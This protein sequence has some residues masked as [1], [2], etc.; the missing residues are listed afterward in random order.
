M[1]KIR[2]Q[3][4]YSLIEL[5]LVLV[6]IG[7]IASIAFRSLG[8]VTETA[9]V[10]ETRSEMERLADAITGD[11]NSVSGGHRIDYGYLGDVGAL[12]PNLDALVANPGGYATWNGPY[13]RD[14][15]SSGGADTYY[16]VD[17]WG[18]PYA[19]S[20]GLTITSNGGGSSLTRRLAN[21]NA[22]LLSNNVRGVILDIDGTPPGPL[23]RDS[24]IVRLYHP[25]G[26][27]GLRTRV[28][29]PG[30]DGFY[31]L[32]SVPVGS[33][34]LQVIYEPTDDTLTRRIDINPGA[35]FYSEIHFYGNIWSGGLSAN[36]LILRPIAE[37]SATNL[38]AEP[39]GPGSLNWDRVNDQFADEDNSY[40]WHSS[41]SYVR[42]LYV[43][44]DPTASGT[45]DSVI[46]V[47]RCK[48]TLPAGQAQTVLLVGGSSFAT[49]LTP[50]ATYAD[51]RASYVTNPNTG[52][53]WSWSDV[54]L[55]E[56]G[57]DIRK[58]AQCTQLYVEIYYAN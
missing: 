38:D 24:V 13:I 16:K 41:P 5:V 47:A 42:D 50:T 6:I 34:E 29:N 7:I 22:E 2:S 4:G 15:F 23:E 19:Y 28:I 14:R 44:E 51:Y 21:S 37:G 26:T 40:V 45:I 25:D 11:P 55:I 27:G 9:R 17:A 56:A 1:P 12:P 54:A 53:P 33:H 46:I 8:T 57:L 49:S 36:R 52:V 32:D 3:A 20:G 48:K 58:S 30:S 43:I 35:D 39:A 10:E 31:Q 18:A